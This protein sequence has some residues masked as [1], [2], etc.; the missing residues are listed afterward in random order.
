MASV[1]ERTGQ[2][3]GRWQVTLA[4]LIVLV[5]GAGLAAGVVRGGRDVGAM[6]QRV[7]GVAVEVAAVF[8]ALILARSMLELARRRAGDAGGTRIGRLAAMAWRG[9]AV[10]LLIGFVV[11]ESEVLRID[12]KT[13]SARYSGTP[14]WWEW[15]TLR[16]KLVPISPSWRCSAWRSGRAREW[17]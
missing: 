7:A 9:L 15:Y 6:P 14:G 2:A 5:L 3:V 11:Q 17:P 10:A 1:E 12:M 8:L 4:D 16:E 13:R